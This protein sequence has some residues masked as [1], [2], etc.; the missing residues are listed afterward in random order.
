M[1]VERM[2]DGLFNHTHSEDGN[3]AFLQ[4]TDVSQPH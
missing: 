4:N 2:T 1:V 3:N